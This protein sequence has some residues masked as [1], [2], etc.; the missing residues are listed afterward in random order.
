MEII[1]IH[2]VFGYFK[3]NNYKMLL[4]LRR[5]VTRWRT[6]YVERE[7]CKRRKTHLKVTKYFSEL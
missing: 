6:V 4:L 7:K 1:P 5:G 2:Y 3:Q